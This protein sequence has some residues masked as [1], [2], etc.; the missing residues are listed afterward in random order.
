MATLKTQ[1]N[2]ELKEAQQELAQ[3]IELLEE[4]PD[5]GL[6]TGSTGSFTWEM[7]LA[8]RE[9]IEEH[10][11]ELEEAIERADKGSYGICESCGKPIDPE[12]LEIVPTATQCIECARLGVPVG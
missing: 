9:R 10:I 11:A 1:L 4:K 2:R 3:V 8:R 5:F 12:R 6:G 7:N